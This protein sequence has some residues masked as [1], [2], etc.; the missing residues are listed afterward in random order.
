MRL[1]LDFLGKIFVITNVTMYLVLMNPFDSHN[2]KFI[3]L[4]MK[5]NKNSQSTLF[6]KEI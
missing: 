2:T 1:Y 3:S 5:I 6:R 4:G